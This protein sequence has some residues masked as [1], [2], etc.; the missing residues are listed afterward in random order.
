THTVHAGV[1]RSAKQRRDTEVTLRMGGD[2]FRVD[3]AG[4]AQQSGLLYKLFE[5]RRIGERAY[6]SGLSVA[7]LEYRYARGWTVWITL[8]F[9][10]ETLVSTRIY[11][12]LHIQ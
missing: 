1:V 10:P 2:G 5:S 3:Y 11:A 7:Q 6:F 4:Q 8:C 12:M 9:A